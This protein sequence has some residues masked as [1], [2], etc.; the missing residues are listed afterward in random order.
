MRVRNYILFILFTFLLSTICSLLWAQDE[1][2]FILDISS[3]TIP[4]PRIFY[5]NIDISGRGFSGDLSWPQTVAANEVINRWQKEIGFVGVYR[6]QYNLW[7]IESLRTNRQM[8]ERLIAHYDGLIKK[9]N[10]AGGLVILNIFSTPETQGKVLDRKSAPGDIRAFK[11]FIK[12]HIRRISCTKKLNVW[13]EVWTAPDLDLFFLGRDQEYLQIYRAVAESARELEKETKVHI[14][15]GGPGTS[16]WFRSSEGNTIATPERSLIYNLIKF[17]YRYRLPLDFISWHAYSTD[18][19]VDKETTPY[20]KSAVALI[21]DW[22]SYFNF[23]KDTPLVISEW[24]YDNGANIT[25]D[26]KER[27][28]VTASYI[29]ARLKNM[30]EADINQ[31]IFFC[32]ED[33]QDNREGVQRNLG[34]FWFEQQEKGYTGGT[35]TIYNVFQLLKKLGSLLYVSSSK[36]NDEFV[37]VLATR[38]PGL[39]DTDQEAETIAILVYNY[40]DPDIFRSA[41][42]RAIG[43]LSDGERK[44]FLSVVRSGELVKIKDRQIDINNLRVSSKVKTLLKKALEL[45]Q[46]QQRLSQQPRQFK[47]SLKQLKRQAY[48]YSRFV[49]DSSC[50]IN[51]EFYPR[52]EKVI[53]P[54]EESYSEKISLAPYSVHLIL[55][56]PR[57]QEVTANPETEA[58]QPTTTDLDKTEQKKSDG[59]K[60][61]KSSDSDTVSS[62]YK[63]NSKYTVKSDRVKEQKVNTSAP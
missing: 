5:P 24:N 28:F 10:D 56:T 63:S 54:V 22:L 27:S 30:F 7:E 41:I 35:K 59:N 55:L 1:I 53:V 14:P 52:E 26:R 21:R 50:P 16:W 43:S 2:E 48:N 39:N 20:N 57:R 3:A 46:T 38:T 61:D 49:I 60:D 51:C 37:G 15:V 44:K 9:I 4:L 6:L 12:R 32:L 45:H 8:Q 31:Q 34:A 11:T 36:L 25:A 33:F 29:P 19:R 62:A 23:S 42:S 40:L 17:C 18:P 58:V 13:Y 47:L